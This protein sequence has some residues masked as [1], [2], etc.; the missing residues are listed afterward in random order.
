[1]LKKTLITT[2]PNAGTSGCA[3]LKCFSAYRANR[4]LSSCQELTRHWCSFTAIQRSKSIYTFTFAARQRF[5]IT[6]TEE[7]G[8]QRKR[9][10]TDRSFFLGAAK[11]QRKNRRAGPT[12]SRG[13]SQGFFLPEDRYLSI[14]SS[15]I[16]QLCFPGHDWPA[17]ISL[18][19]LSH[20]EQEEDCARAGK[21]PN[22]LKEI[23]CTK[24]EQSGHKLSLH[25]FQSPYGLMKKFHV[26]NFVFC[27][28]A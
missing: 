2:A 18:V 15:L 17:S 24:L 12:R 11:E 13:W 10:G 8:S 6:R 5:L 1:M 3:T 16:I 27:K 25:H 21:K 20:L 23:A 26:K 9:Y 19:R 22:K 28:I 7:C 14:P 4:M